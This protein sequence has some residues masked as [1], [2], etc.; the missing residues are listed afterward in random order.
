MSCLPVKTLSPSAHPLWVLF[1][2]AVSDSQECVW[3]WVQGGSARE[4]VCLEVERDH[5]GNADQNHPEAAEGSRSRPVDGRQPP[6]PPAV[7]LEPP[8]ALPF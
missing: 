4:G 8:S 3:C 7:K 2:Q 1:P 6:V 5:W